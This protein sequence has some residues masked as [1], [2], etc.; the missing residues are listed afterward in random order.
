MIHSPENRRENPATTPH[1]TREISVSLVDAGE[2]GWEGF[3]AVFTP[4]SA[5][6]VPGLVSQPHRL[7]AKLSYR[8]KPFVSVPIEVSPMEAG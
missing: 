7:T 2:E 5:F 1:P 3:T 6:T 4:A 8:H